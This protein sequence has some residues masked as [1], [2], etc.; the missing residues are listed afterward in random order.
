MLN[1]CGEYAYV[2]HLQSEH[3]RVEQLI[4]HAAAALPNWEETDPAAWQPRVVE[5]LLAIR[6]EMAHHFHNEEQGGCLEEAVA[7]CPNLSSEVARIEGEHT[8]LLADID[9]LIR[10]TEQ[11][12]HPT[13]LD[14]QILRQELRAIVQALRDHEAAENRVMQRGFG[15][16]P[17]NREP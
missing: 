2:D 16:D 10:S 7:H 17:E 13:V 4:C 1:D 9:D 3:R 8:R 5:G 6:N 11:I 14:A 15:L 12:E